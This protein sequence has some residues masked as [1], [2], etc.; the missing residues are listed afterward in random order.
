MALA[1]TLALPRLAEAAFPGMSTANLKLKARMLGAARKQAAGLEPFLN[2]APG[3]MLAH[4][5]AQRPETLGALVWPYQC[6]AW[7]AE[8]RLDRIAAHYA[9]IDRLGGPFIF[10]LDEKRVLVTL[11]DE[12]PGLRLVLDQPKWF[13]REGGLVLNAF[14]GDFRA[15]SLAFS[16]WPLSGGGLAAVIGG[17]QGRNAED[18]LGLY[19][20]LTKDLHGLRPRDFLLEAFRMLARH[21]GVTEIHGVT[22]AQRHHV[23]PFFGEKNLDKAALTPDYDA[24][25]ED[26]GGTRM[27]DHF[28][29]LDVA[30]EPRDLETVK[31][32]K[33]SLYRKRFAFLD[34][35]EPALVAGLDSNPP[36]RFTDS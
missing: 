30:P 6:A 35:L 27:N 10:D 7:D 2:P 24:I 11:E 15:F 9:E 18:A 21:M 25:W 29:R 14:V 26:R 32:K 3:T 17:L 13:M 19:R 33:R 36:I 28:W 12:H 5:M 31:P 34:A 1:G 23:H 20:Q 8:D 22:Q 16:L 4:V